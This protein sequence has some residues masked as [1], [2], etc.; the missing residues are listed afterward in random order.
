MGR[1][2]EQQPEPPN[3]DEIDDLLSALADDGGDLALR[4]RQAIVA[5]DRDRRTLRSEVGQLDEVARLRRRARDMSLAA[6][7]HSDAAR[8]LL[9]LLVGAE[10]AIVDGHLVGTANPAGVVVD[11][12][13]A[14]I[15]TRVLEA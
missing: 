7:Q 9:S 1:P 11:E 4:A 14:K 6:T 3:A 10:A 5:L 8:V 2:V 13:E 15:L 12:H